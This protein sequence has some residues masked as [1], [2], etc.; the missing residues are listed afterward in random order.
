LFNALIGAQSKLL[1]FAKDNTVWCGLPPQVVVSLKE[2]VGKVTEIRTRV[3]Q[4]AAAP[5][6]PSAP[7]L[8]DALS[9]PVPNSNNIK[10]GR[11]TFDTLTGNPLEKK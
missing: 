4:A 3:C 10:T 9:S 6:R 7:S 1:K 11:G 8:S 2:A 5:Q